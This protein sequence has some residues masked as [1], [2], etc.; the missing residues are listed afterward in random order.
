MKLSFTSQYQWQLR[1]AQGERPRTKQSSRSGMYVPHQQRHNLTHEAVRCL[2][3]FG[4]RENTGCSSS[5]SLLE[6]LLRKIQNRATQSQQVFSPFQ[7]RNTKKIL[8]KLTWHLEKFSWKIYGS[9]GLS[10]LRRLLPN[11]TM[12]FLC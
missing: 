4:P 7:P 10:S 11:S 3:L 2:Y 8:L 1:P 9:R 6:R 12:L 5:S